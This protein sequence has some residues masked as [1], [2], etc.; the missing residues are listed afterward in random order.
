VDLAGSWRGAARSPEL[1]RAGADPDLDDDDWTALDVPGHWGQVPELESEVGPVMYRRRFAHGGPGAGRRAWLRF[2][3]VLSDA[4]V[5]L[6]GLHLGDLRVYFATHRF[7]VT[8]LLAPGGSSRTGGTDRSPGVG[9]EHL[10]AVEVSCPEPGRKAKRSL[11]GSLQSGPLAPPGSPGGIWG[12]V[13]IDTTG[14][15]AIVRS[16][17]LC[18]SATGTAAVLRFRLELDAAA[19]G[20]IRI[21]TSIVGPDGSTAGGVASHD[22]ASGRNHIEWTSTIADPHLWWPHSLGDQPRYDVGVAVRTSDGELSDRCHWRTGLRSVTVD[23][24]QWAVNGERLFAK[25][26][27]IGP[28]S[29]FLAAVDPARFAA[30]IRLAREAG[31]NLIRVHGHVSRPELYDAADDLGVLIW[32]DLPLVGTYSTGSRSAAREVARAAVDELG[33]HPSIAAWCGH[34]EP[35]GPP[36]P[37]PD[38]GIEPLARLGRRLGRHLSPSWNRS[39]LDPLVRREL[40]SADRS[41]S[42]ITRSG[43]LPN[44]FDFSRSD[45]HLWLGW[46][47]GRAEDLAELLRTWPRLATFVGAIGTQSV[48]VGDW[49]PDAP[50]FATAQAGAFERYL[51]RGAYADGESWALATRAYQA[52][53]IRAQIETIRRLKYR[54]AG[55]FCVVSLFDAEAEGGFGI[56]DADHQPKP[57]LDVVID[58]CRPVVVIA[59][60]PPPIVTEGQEVELAV[61]AV[62]DLR[63]DLEPVQVTA[64]ARLDDWLIER[65]W[66]GK[67]PA[68]SCSFIGSLSFTVP[69]LTGA[70]VID[71]ELETPD[72]AASNRYQTVVIPPSESLR[73]LADR[74]RHGS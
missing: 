44:L 67:V 48:A 31:L 28:H 9:A 72:R 55:G 10:L 65:R 66:Q 42:V 64:T 5:W 63:S 29:R 17:L 58:C 52:D 20:P 8:D 71:L 60:P 59:D 69:D 12:P 43:N 24:L 7:D 61:H 16:R 39:V 27:V 1:D 15:V 35:N 3:G 51:P 62:S 45:T 22:V 21:D 26:V 49:P 36:L 41:R 34:D 25:G 54:P 6:D 40:R 47:S 56:V 4:E 18:A 68:D 2:D 14:P 53:V 13:G 37:A 19:A 11:T 50:T 46:H 30:D 73:S 70:L 32:Q 23:D 33:H 57:A 38:G 74:P